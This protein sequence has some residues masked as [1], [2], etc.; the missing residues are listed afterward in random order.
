M[1]GLGIAVGGRV[2][3]SPLVAEVSGVFGKEMDEMVVSQVASPVLLKLQAWVVKVIKV[4]CPVCQQLE[5]DFLISGIT[6]CVLWGLYIAF[7]LL[8]TNCF[9]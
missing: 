3:V 8:N 6:N 9:S 7:L 4:R 2:S 5:S 1:A